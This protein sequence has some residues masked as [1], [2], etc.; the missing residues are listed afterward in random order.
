MTKIYRDLRQAA[1]LFGARLDAIKP[2]V[3]VSCWRPALLGLYRFAALN[4]V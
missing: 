3:L 2:E 1:E 4:E